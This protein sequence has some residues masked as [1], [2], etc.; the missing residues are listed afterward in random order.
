MY[1]CCRSD[2]YAV[3]RS[4]GYAVGLK[5][6]PAAILVRLRRIKTKI[7]FLRWLPI[8]ANPKIIK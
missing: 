2:G 8:G 7:L 6:G 5:L 4:D 1:A 3:Y